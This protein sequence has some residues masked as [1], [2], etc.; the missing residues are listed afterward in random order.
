[1]TNKPSPALSEPL[2]LPLRKELG[3][4]AGLIAK[5]PDGLIGRCGTTVSLRYLEGLLR[6]ASDAIPV[7]RELA[8][9]SNAPDNVAALRYLARWYKSIQGFP[10]ADHEAIVN[11]LNDA[12]DEIAQLRVV[13]AGSSSPGGIAAEPISLGPNRQP[14][15]NEQLPTWEACADKRNSSKS[16]TA[17]EEFI[18]DNEPAP[19]PRSTEE[20]DFRTQL[21][22]VLIEQRTAPET[23]EQP[24]MAAAD[25]LLERIGHVTGIEPE[26][27]A[28]LAFMPSTKKAAAHSVLTEPGQEARNRFAQSPD[29]N[30]V[31]AESRAVAALINPSGQSEEHPY[32]DRPRHEDGSSEESAFPASDSGPSL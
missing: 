22:A 18:F 25:R 2:V 11:A 31:E 14:A 15:S 27:K 12:A 13:R 28:L 21:L 26:R 3:D 19:N 29:D 16:L 4:T 7:D 30:P 8:P 32:N 6:R 10:G 9:A 17:L 1:M 5:I 23:P 20:E 24:W